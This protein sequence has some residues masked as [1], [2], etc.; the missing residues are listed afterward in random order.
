MKR[1]FLLTL[2]MVLF[3]FYTVGNC[4]TIPNIDDYVFKMKNGTLYYC[5]KTDYTVDAGHLS[6]WNFPKDMSTEDKNATMMKYGD[7]KYNWSSAIPGPLMKELLIK[8]D[9]ED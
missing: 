6:N 9:F 1:I 5:N 4:Y 8:Y 2:S 7:R 3:L